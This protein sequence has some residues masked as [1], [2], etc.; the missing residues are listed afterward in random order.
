MVWQ[1]QQYRLG[2][3]TTLGFTSEVEQ[4]QGGLFSSIR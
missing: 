3:H 4:R 1:T 2:G